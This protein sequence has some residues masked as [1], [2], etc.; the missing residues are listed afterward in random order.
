MS[1]GVGFQKPALFP[2]RL[3]S[4][5]LG[6]RC[7]LPAAAPCLTVRCAAVRHDD[8]GLISETAGPKLNAVFCKLPWSWCFCYNNWKVTKT[9]YSLRS[10]ITCICSLRP[11]VWKERTDFT[12]CKH[13][14]H[15]DAD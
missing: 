2:V 6:P 13:T 10:L 14:E 1:L 4:L 11:T 9:G 12:L 7:K 15:T 3:L 5:V 8:R